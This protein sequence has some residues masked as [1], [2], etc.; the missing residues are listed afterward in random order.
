MT[1]ISAKF[2]MN[3]VADAYG[4]FEI[5][6]GFI[7]CGCEQNSQSNYFVCSE[8]LKLLMEKTAELWSWWECLCCI[9]FFFFSFLGCV[10]L[11]SSRKAILKSNVEEEF[12][13]A[14]EIASNQVVHC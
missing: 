6:H 4:M 2:N 3:S 14:E 9:F 13:T 1:L 8:M 10:T 5:G 11:L 12:P 7:L